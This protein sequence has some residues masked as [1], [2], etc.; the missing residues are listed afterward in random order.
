M[1]SKFRCVIL[2]FR[3]MTAQPFKQ[4]P[5]APA[6][7]ATPYVLL[8]SAMLVW[9]G[10]YIV[11]RAIHAD[12]TP[13][14]LNFWRWLAVTL[15]LVAMTPRHLW[16]QRHVAARHWLVLL[17]TGFT[18]IAVFPVLIFTA[19]GYTTATNGVL[20]ISTM[21]V[22]I[23][24]MS[25]LVNRE[26]ITPRQALGVVV[27]LAGVVTIVSHGRPALLLELEI[28]PGDALMLVAVVI[29]AVYAVLLKR[30]PVGFRPT[31]FLALISGWGTVCLL[32]LYLWELWRGSATTHFGPGLLLSLVYL[33]IFVSILGFTF[34][35]MGVAQI[36]ANRAGLFNHLVPV[37]TVI[38]AA[39]FLG[40]RLHAFHLVGVAF[41]GVG[42]A[43]S[44]I[45]RERAPRSR[46]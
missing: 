43:L 22:A 34:Y 7:G 8:V 41:I 20:V 9:A 31:A 38:L 13:I 42:I 11:A 37:F 28:N 46:P 40:E 17:L 19:L 36:G 2:L 14:S 6:H 30:Q 29:W 44:S 24:V 18:G 10:N 39:I 15:A 12:V 27:S 16:R 33:T 5:P 35:N 45:A 25:W 26:G 4:T 3:P 32:P 21:P 23:M 1:V